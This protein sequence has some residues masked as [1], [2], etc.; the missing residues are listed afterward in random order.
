MIDDDRAIFM[1]KD[2]A[3]AWIAKD[4]LIEQEECKEVSIESKIYP[5]NNPDT[6]NSAIK[7]KEEL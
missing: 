2:G 6:I 5:G 7:P 3:Q 1:F 4:Y